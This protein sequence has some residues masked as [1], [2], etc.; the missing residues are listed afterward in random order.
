MLQA[1]ISDL[2]NSHTETWQEDC[3]FNVAL[4]E[5]AMGDLRQAARADLGYDPP[6]TKEGF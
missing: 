5:K 3:L 1:S 2:R 6:P 4:L